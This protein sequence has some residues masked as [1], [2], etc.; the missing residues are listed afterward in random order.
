MLL[1]YLVSIIAHVLADEKGSP[2]FAL[3]TTLVN[4][5]KEPPQTGSQVLSAAVFYL[6]ELTRL[7]EAVAE[8]LPDAKELLVRLDK[9][10][11]PQHLLYIPYNQF[12]DKYHWEGEEISNYH[13]IVSYTRRVW[14][15]ML[16]KELG[17][18]EYF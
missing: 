2:L 18:E 15:E 10:G 11:G 4:Y 13:I 16:V 6:H 5:Y 1:F 3:N 7:Q 9:D 14:D 12:I 17:K 8:R